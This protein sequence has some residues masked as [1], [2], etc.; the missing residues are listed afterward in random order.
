MNYSCKC[1]CVNVVVEEEPL[2]KNTHCIVH[3]SVPP[4]YMAEL[5]RSGSARTS[6]YNL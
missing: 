6:H 5:W 1:M 4:L 2:F 3:S